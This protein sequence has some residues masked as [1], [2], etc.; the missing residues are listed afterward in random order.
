MSDKF[1]K[2]IDFAPT[3]PRFTI[4]R[5]LPRTEWGNKIIEDTILGNEQKRQ[6]NGFDIEKIIREF[7]ELGNFHSGEIT[8]IWYGHNPEEKMPNHLMELEKQESLEANRLINKVMGIAFLTM[9]SVSPSI[10]NIHSIEELRSI[11]THK[12]P[13]STEDIIRV[14]QA[15]I[16]I[17][18][19]HII[20]SVNRSYNY[21]KV[22]AAS[23]QI[24]NDLWTEAREQAEQ[25]KKPLIEGGIINLEGDQIT[26]IHQDK[27]EK[28]PNHW[29]HGFRFNILVDD[30]GEL[31]KEQPIIYVSPG[32]STESVVVKGLNKNIKHLDIGVLDSTRLMIEWPKGTLSRMSEEERHDALRV[33]GF[34]MQKKFGTNI[35]EAEGSDTFATESSKSNPYSTGVEGRMKFT[36]SCRPNITAETVHDIGRK[37][38]KKADEVKRNRLTQDIITGD[39]IRISQGR[40]PIFGRIQKRIYELESV[41]ESLHGREKRLNSGGIRLLKELLIQIQQTEVVLPHSTDVIIDISEK[42]VSMKRGRT[43]IEDP[44]ESI[45]SLNEIPMEVQMKEHMPEKEYREDHKQYIYRKNHAIATSLGLPHRVVD[46]KDYICGLVELIL[47]GG[48]TSRM[49]LVL[50]Q[51]P[52]TNHNVNSRC[53]SIRTHALLLL[54]EILANKENNHIIQSILKEDPETQSPDDQR[55]VGLKTAI[56]RV[57]TETIIHSVPQTKVHS[58]DS[59]QLEIIGEITELKIPDYVLIFQD[60]IR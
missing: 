18:F 37:I 29:H 52:I 7:F 1:N 13:K 6:K 31:A 34:L 15:R 14:Q 26:F 24:E 39:S 48:G 27:Q 49:P 43:A 59:E 55:V 45:N 8:R 32:K 46:I 17:V 30:D 28:V 3:E 16:K 23:R 9:G 5:H 51:S 10:K 38:V 2:A 40:V 47:S 25:R 57:I 50:M 22:A 56:Q 4:S 58:I 19:R 54:R 36:M 53:R 41:R 60:E 42:T 11:A 35:I 12:V 20:R 44:D 21:P 33:V